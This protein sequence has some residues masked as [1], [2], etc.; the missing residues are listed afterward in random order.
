MPWLLCED[1]G[2]R[3]VPLPDEHAG[4]LA[5]AGGYVQSL[6]DAGRVPGDVRAWV[7]AWV[8]DDQESLATASDFGALV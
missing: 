6:V 8:P 3:A 2:R 7:L 5:A 4:S 1:G